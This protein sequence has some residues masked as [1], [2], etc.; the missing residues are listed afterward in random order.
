MQE[1]WKSVRKVKVIQTESLVHGLLSP[2]CK[3]GR[4]SLM[5]PVAAGKTQVRVRV[6]GYQCAIITIS[7][8]GQFTSEKFKNVGV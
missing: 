3:I 6:R 7:S 4:I 2:P 1:S 5:P 8:V